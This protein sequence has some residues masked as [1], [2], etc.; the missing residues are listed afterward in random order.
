MWGGF[1]TV[2]KPKAVPTTDLGPSR[3]SFVV[4]YGKT[5]NSIGRIAMRNPLFREEALLT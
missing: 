4:S 5:R 3:R 1:R 2:G